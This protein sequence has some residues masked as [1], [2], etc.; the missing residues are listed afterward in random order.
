MSWHSRRVVAEQPKASRKLG[1]VLRL[2]IYLP[3]LG[4]FGWQAWERFG[5][6]REA[7]DELFREQLSAWLEQ[8]TH[9]ITLPNGEALPMLTPEQA[10]AQGY[11]LPA[12]FFEDAPAPAPE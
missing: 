7:A 3:L 11:E 4:F 6:A 12:A 1:L 8:P 10:R 5:N 9:M 2:A